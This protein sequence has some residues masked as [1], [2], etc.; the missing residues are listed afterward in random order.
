MARI[1]MNILSNKIIIYFYIF[2]VKNDEAKLDGKCIYYI[3]L[4][5]PNLY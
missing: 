2:Q 4:I 1:G 3:A 5:R